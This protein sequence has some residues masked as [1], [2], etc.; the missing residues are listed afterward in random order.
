MHIDIF[1]S[2]FFFFGEWKLWTINLITS[3]KRR[4]TIIF[5]T[6]FITSLGK[7]DHQTLEFILPMSFLAKQNM[8]LYL[9]SYKYDYIYECLNSERVSKCPPLIKIIE[10]G[11]LLF[12][13]IAV[14]NNFKSPSISKS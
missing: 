6:I 3:I 9:L 8:L 10:L 4:T 14:Y 1:A 2:F 13:V 7:F 11:K 12:F 5:K